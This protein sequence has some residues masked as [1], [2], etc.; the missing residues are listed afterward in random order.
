MPTPPLSDE[1]LQEAV[2]AYRNSGHNKTHGA[3]SLGMDRST[4]VH[5]L[6]L[7][8]PR[9]L[10]SPEE[11]IPGFVYTSV[12]TRMD[13]DGNPTGY[14]TTQKPE[15]PEAG[16]LP[17]GHRIKG[18]SRYED[19][20]GNLRGQWIKT[21]SD[22]PDPV[23]IARKIAEAFDGKKFEL[24]RI[25]APQ[26]LE[27]DLLTLY[28]LADIHL[29]MMAWGEETRENWDLKIALKAM[30]ETMSSIFTA[31]PNSATGVI[32]GCGD[33][34]HSD[35]KRNETAQHGNP[36]DVDGRYQ[37]VLEAACDF[38]AELILLALQK[39]EHV[40]A[41][42]V[43]GNH[44]EYSAIAI[45]SFLRGVF[46]QNDRVTV[47]NSPSDYWVHSF[48]K[49][50]LVATHGH[51]IKPQKLQDFVTSAYRKEWGQAEHVHGFVGHFHHKEKLANENGGMLVEILP[52][53]IPPD[54]YHYGA[55]YMS[56]LALM[57][58][59]YHRE[60][61]EISRDTRTLRAA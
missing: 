26:K 20:Q 6:K 15:N 25:S 24:P 52:A 45:T 4:F 17:E 7:A 32:L 55:G 22:G 31:T 34:L 50:L 61:G 23:E 48:G 1:V 39:H 14:F 29:G 33:F 57:G 60:H 54:A 35:N 51:K 42:F 21:V 19:G 3:D 40:I 59:T 18:I 41:R 56:G 16:P 28:P 37:K 13:G 44:D 12:S 46:A 27:L 11:L 8:V 2:D 9:G 38:A 36:L 10:I 58:I 5:R 49:C 30:R 47:D 53:P 43:P